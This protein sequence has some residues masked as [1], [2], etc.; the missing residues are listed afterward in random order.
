MALFFNLGW[1]LF[2]ETRSN[3]IKDADVVIRRR[4]DSIAMVA[5]N[6]IC[7]LTLLP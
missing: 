4:P 6:E 5:R 1:P 3:E 7:P 2:D